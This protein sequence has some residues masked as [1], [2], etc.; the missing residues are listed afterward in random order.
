MKF[1][2]P[3]PLARFFYLGL[4]T[5][6]APGDERFGFALWRFYVGCYGPDVGVP[7]YPSGW[8]CGLLDSTGCL[9]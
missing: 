8:C 4:D 6:A 9:R 7:G 1:S 3:L 5:T 2:T